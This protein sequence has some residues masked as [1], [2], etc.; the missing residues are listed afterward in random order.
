MTDSSNMPATRATPLGR[1]A[2][3][4]V[5]GLMC[6]FPAVRI[7]PSLHFMPS[8][9][10]NRI[11]DYAIAWLTGL[12]FLL[13]LVLCWRGLRWAAFAV[14]PG[15]LGFT[16]SEV[17]VSAELGPFGKWSTRW[18]DL[19]VEW[20]DYLFDLDLDENEPLPMNECP[21][22]RSASGGP[23]IDLQLR[24]FGLLP[25]GQWWP[26]LEPRLRPSLFSDSRW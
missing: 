19:V 15:R 3:L 9:A 5:L 1:A 14:W 12:F 26:I 11:T 18:S 2:L 13:G 16:L 10:S 8:A 4:A 20:P 7:W 21:P 24:R 22:V 23:R 17:G 6:M 25:E